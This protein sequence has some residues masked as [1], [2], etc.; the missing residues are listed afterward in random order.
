MKHI[1]CNS[2]LV[3]CVIIYFIIFLVW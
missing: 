2:R 3:W 1:W